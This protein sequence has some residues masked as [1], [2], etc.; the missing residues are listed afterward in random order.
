MI[1]VLDEQTLRPV[2]AID[3]CGIQSGNSARIAEKQDD[4]L[5]ARFG[6]ER[7]NGKSENK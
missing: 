4:I 7:T 2:V 3:S 5:C 1:H 6:G